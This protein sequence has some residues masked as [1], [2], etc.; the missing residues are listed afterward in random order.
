VEYDCVTYAA[1]VAKL[2]E[3]WDYCLK[4]EQHVLESR[5]RR[6]INWFLDD[7]A[8]DMSRPEQATARL[9]AIAR[10][11]CAALDAMET[12]ATS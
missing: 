5:Y 3:A 4:I 6:F 9:V 12:G 8:V 2:D 11:T 7:Y 1:S 10:Q